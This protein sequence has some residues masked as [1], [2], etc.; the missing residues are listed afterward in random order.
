MIALLGVE[1]RLWRRSRNGDDIW[2]LI[3]ALNPSLWPGGAASTPILDVLAVT[4]DPNS[5]HSDPS[6]VEEI[7]KATLRLVFQSINDFR[8]DIV[9]IFTNESDLVADIGEDLTREALDRIG[10]SVI[11]VRLFGKMDYKR[12]RYLFFPEFSVRQA[13][14]V[15]SKAEKGSQVIRLQQGQTSMIIRQIRATQRVE[16]QGGL[17]VA[18]P[19]E[20]GALLTT[21]VFVKYHYVESD[22]KK[23]LEKISVV[24]LPSGLL[25]ERYNPNP[26]DT[27]W[28]AGPNAPSR[29]E[30]FR[31]R[32]S[33]AKL[34]AK[35]RWRV[36]T[37]LPTAALVSQW[38]D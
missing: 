6:R 19:H 13:L 10:T 5:L 16:E 7:E 2:G 28:N 30:K 32:I 21:T 37:I 15:D 8:S 20:S 25:Q 35:A 14:F 3:P 17:P 26:Q 11:P 34:R 9:E 27:I 29:G 22:R 23:R 12:A 1:L 33:L 24:A 38:Q 18:I 4:L 31:A 36:Q